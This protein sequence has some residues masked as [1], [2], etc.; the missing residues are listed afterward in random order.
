MN[1]T[2]VIFSAPMVRALLENRK[3]QTRR[4]PYDKRGKATAWL[5]LHD[6]WHHDGGERG[7]WVREAFTATFQDVDD[8]TLEGRYHETASDHRDRSRVRELSYRVDEEAKQRGWA[9]DAA[10]PAAVL[11]NGWAAPIH[12]PRWASRLTLR[13]TNVR[14]QH[15]QEIAADDAKAEGHPGW[16]ESDRDTYR[17]LP[18]P[19]RTRR[20]FAALWDTLHEPPFAWDDKPDVIAV[21]F[22]VHRCNIDRL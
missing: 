1:D 15:L 7:L 13:V 20:W 11:D 22:T 17:G 4:L 10:A 9:V 16:Q 19:E 6:A 21:S 3:T 5:R 14:R 2:P 8:P 18:Y 12:M